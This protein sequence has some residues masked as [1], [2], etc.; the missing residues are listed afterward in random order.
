MRALLLAS[1]MSF[2]L[3]LSS[4]SCGPGSQCESVIG[5]LELNP[6]GSSCEQRCECNNQRYTGICEKGTCRSIIRE[7]C[8]TKGKKRPCVD[9][10]DGRK[11]ECGGIQICQ[12][13]GLKGLFWG[14]CTPLPK[15]VEVCDGRDNDCNGKTDDITKEA[16][17]KLGTACDTGGKGVC[18]PGKFACV[19]G[20]FECKQD[21]PKE[22]EKCDGLDND[23]DG[24]VD[25]DPVFLC[26][27]LDDK[28]CVNGK[29]EKNR[30][31]A[32][33]DNNALGSCKENFECCEDKCKTFPFG[34]FCRCKEAKG[35]PTLEG[36]RLKCCTVQTILG[37]NHFCAKGLDVINGVLT[38]KLRKQLKVTKVECK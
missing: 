10:F 24:V 28:I 13:K 16:E 32:I 33:K 15:T 22:T 31:C 25:E 17:P 14:D 3:V 29:C 21:K 23:C 30:T 37:A 34:R 11:T 19:A 27:D 35:C 38:D 4:I 5:D 6:D 7:V 20:K 26:K 36:V 12:D 18:G 9:Q 2:T 8:D 1:L